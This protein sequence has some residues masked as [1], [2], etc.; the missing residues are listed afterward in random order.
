MS[1]TWEPTL[2]KD[3]DVSKI[4]FSS[5]KTMP[6]GA[7][8]FFLEY[9]GEPLY[10]QSPE[11]SITFDP[12]VF[13]DE[14]NNSS[15]FNIK[16]SLNLENESSKVFHSKLSEFDEHLKKLGKENA[17][18]WFRKKN[19]SDDV[20]ESMFTSTIRDHIDSESGEKSGKYPPTFAWKIKKKDG[21]ILCR[22]FDGSTKERSKEMNFNDPNEDDYLKFTSY[23]K[24]GTL[25]KGLY[26]CDFV[27]HSPGKFGCSWTAQQLR[28]KAPKG[29]DKYAFMDDSDEDDSVDINQNYVD[30]SEDSDDGEVS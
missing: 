19:L 6:N 21:K 3:L 25:V 1:D 15:K 2:P 9:K 4:K 26:K 12:Q 17:K 5:A 10:I 11:M 27:W 14:N 13:D 8:L 22:C 24:K 29:F 28:V 30:S 18:E 20:I 23:V 16:S 7:K